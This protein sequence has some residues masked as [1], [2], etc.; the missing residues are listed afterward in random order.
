M[1]L[2]KFQGLC[3][4]FL[5]LPVQL[6]GGEC[7]ELNSR[8]KIVSYVRESLKANPILRSQ[9]SV[10]L[11]VQTCEGQQ[12]QT[13]EKI[14]HALHLL[15][16]KEQERIFFS[17]GPQT[18][19]C[20]VKNNDRSYACIA[21][22]FNLS[23]ECRPFAKSEQVSK[24]Q[25]TN[26]DMD[27]FQKLVDDTSQISCEEME[28]PQGVLK[29]TNQI[30]TPSPQSYDTIITYYELEK[31]VPLMVQFYNQNVLRK[32]YRFFPK[33]YVK[34]NDQWLATVIRIR[35]VAGDE[36]NY[37]FETLVYVSKDTHNNYRLFTDPAKDPLI[38]GVLG[39][40]FNME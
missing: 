3:L 20:L 10:Y 1:N 25:G 7:G 22:D 26:L 37:L 14:E 19:Q 39:N 5:L 31:N 29:I 27:D 23:S 40:M 16:M 30:S 32:V 6:W 28:N 35:S 34:I 15:K 24:V 18:P 2:T 38:N 12:C 17:R 8:E 36:Q 11:E 4:L 13:N 9:L 33:Y 21:C